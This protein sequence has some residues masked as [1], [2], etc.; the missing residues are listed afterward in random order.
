MLVWFWANPILYPAGFVKDELDKHDA[1]WAYFL[2]PMATVVSTFQ[3]AIYETPTYV[4]PGETA[5][6]LVL[7]APGYTFYLRNLLI[8]FVL[9]GLLLLLARTV[10]NR[11][12][13]DFAE[14]L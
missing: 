12:Q 6:R 4:R 1:Y 8:G 5:Q 13:A 7:A 11:L 9:S 14:D 3:R 10:F 2:N